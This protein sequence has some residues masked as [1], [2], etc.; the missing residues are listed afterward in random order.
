MKRK[1]EKTKKVDNNE[2][3]EKTN[4]VNN[5]EKEERKQRKVWYNYKK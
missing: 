5:N 2:K 1:R 4:K 3:E